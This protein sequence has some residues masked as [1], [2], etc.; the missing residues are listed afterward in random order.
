MT[1]RLTVL[2]G[3]LGAG[4]TTLL[5]GLLAAAGGVRIAVVVNDFGAVNIDRRLITSATEDTVELSNG[6]ICCSLQD[7]TSA[8]MT[9]LAGRGDLDHVVVE[10][11]GVGDPAALRTWGNYP[12][13]APGSTVVCADSTAVDRL[14]RDEF[15]GDTVARQLTRA[16][17]VVLSKADLAGRAQ[18]TDARRRC[19]EHAAD[20]RVLESTGGD[21]H[22]K[23]LL[24]SAAPADPAA[25]EP[26]PH[27]SVHRSASVTGP[28]PV[29]RDAL[30]A[31]LQE[32]PE[33]VVRLKGVVRCADSPRARTVVQYSGG[34]L[35]VTTDGDWQDADTSGLV[36]IVAGDETADAELRSVSDRLAEVLIL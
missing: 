11:S 20:A 34:R 30:L 26:D 16:D 18:L 21:V 13:F 33:S 28:G 35:S 22:L 8:V 12:G 24:R 9:R 23:D 29:D 27:R 3:Y 5:N 2:G 7:D 25:G 31:A 15:V 17:I 6:C 10:T 19:R 1:A 4:K 32:L 14:L 36:V